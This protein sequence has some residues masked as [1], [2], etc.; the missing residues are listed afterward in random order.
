MLNFVKR[1]MI[2][3]C[4]RGKN[5]IWKIGASIKHLK[6]ECCIITYKIQS[7]SSMQSLPEEGGVGDLFIQLAKPFWVGL[8]G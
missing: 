7:Y 8:E 2:R 3:S 5:A 1:F 6:G 4:R